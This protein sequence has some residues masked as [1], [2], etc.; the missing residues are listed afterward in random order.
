MK[1]VFFA[2]FSYG[3]IYYIYIPCPI[4]MGRST[5]AWIELIEIQIVLS[6]TGDNTYDLNGLY[7]DFYLHVKGLTE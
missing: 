3:S 4:N 1:F 2:S 5:Q 6:D 7:Y